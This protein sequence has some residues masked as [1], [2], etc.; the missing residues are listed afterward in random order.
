M[1]KTAKSK[2]TLQDAIGVNAV[3]EGIPGFK[4]GEIGL[5]QFLAACNAAAVLDREYATKDA[6]SVRSE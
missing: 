2:A 1:A 5:D 6:E 3:W 4:L